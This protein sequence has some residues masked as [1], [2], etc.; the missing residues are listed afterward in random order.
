MIGPTVIHFTPKNVNPKSAIA[1]LMF[2]KRLQMRY[3]VLVERLKLRKASRNCKL[4]G[5]VFSKRQNNQ[6]NHCVPQG[7]P[8]RMAY[9]DRER[10]LKSIAGL[11]MTKIMFKEPH[12]V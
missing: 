7:L 1:F 6:W 9:S 11:S 12:K 8:S 5:N 10:V 4:F 2:K 3:R